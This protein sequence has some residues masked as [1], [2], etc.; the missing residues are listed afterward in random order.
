M[1]DNKKTQ[2]RESRFPLGKC[3]YE[4]KMKN[5]CAYTICMKENLNTFH[6]SEYYDKHT[7]AAAPIL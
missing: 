7:S 1:G 6:T 3:I 4:N 2:A 5:A